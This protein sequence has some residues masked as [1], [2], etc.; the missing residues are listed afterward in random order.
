MSGIPFPTFNAD[1]IME[2]LDRRSGKIIMQLVKPT[3]FSH[4][5]LLFKFPYKMLI[6][7]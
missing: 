6:L 7:E 2:K 3:L 4:G 5:L 1:I